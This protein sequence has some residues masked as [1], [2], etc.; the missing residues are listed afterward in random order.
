MLSIGPRV[1]QP[2]QTGTQTNGIANIARSPSFS[3]LIATL[4]ID[5]SNCVVVLQK[6]LDPARAEKSATV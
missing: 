1:P 6:Q 3:M 2:V 5:K 4:L